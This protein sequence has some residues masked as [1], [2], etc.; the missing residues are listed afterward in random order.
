MRDE[1]A[2]WI[3][4]VWE[5]LEA[6]GLAQQVVDVHLRNQRY[7][8]SLDWHLYRHLHDC[9]TWAFHQQ[10]YPLIEVALHWL[11]R[12]SQKLLRCYFVIDS[13]LDRMVQ[14]VQARLEA[15]SHQE[16]VAHPR[17]EELLR[18]LL[19]LRLQAQIDHS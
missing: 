13:R 18:R 11:H 19:S 6:L 12:L 16:Q 14:A 15:A 9:V 5:L 4:E 2:A 10:I 17:R 3:Q 1:E 8:G 7:M